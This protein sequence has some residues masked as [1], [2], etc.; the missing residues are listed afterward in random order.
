MPCGRKT[1]KS[2]RLDF[3]GVVEEEKDKEEE[4]E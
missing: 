3:G 1:V 2:K 4:Y